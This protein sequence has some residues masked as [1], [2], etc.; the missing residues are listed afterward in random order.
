MDV[1]EIVDRGSFE[2][3]LEDLP[4]ERR[5][6]WSVTLATRAALRAFPIWTAEMP[7]EWARKRDLTVL[8]LSRSLL[9][10]A[11]AVKMPTADIKDA[12]AASADAASAASADAADAS[13]ASNALAA[14]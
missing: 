3:W 13:A 9:I 7:T 11:V 10:S 8:P 4:E 6:E 12:S 5:F 1:S 2:A 14:A